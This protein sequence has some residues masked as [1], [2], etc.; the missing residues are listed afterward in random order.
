MRWPLS[1]QCEIWWQFHD[2]TLTV[3]DTPAH[4]KGYSY[5]AGTSVIAV[6]RIGMQQCMIRNQNERHKLSKVKNGHK[7][8]ALGNFSLTRFFPD[9]SLTSSKIPDISLTAVKFPDISNFHVFNTS[10][11][12]EYGCKKTDQLTPQFTTSH[13]FPND[14]NQKQ[15]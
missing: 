10:G 4:V 9:T 13:D 3:R 7:Y 8:A 5:Y 2:I 14:T 12:P 1:R 11:Y 15:Y 6:V